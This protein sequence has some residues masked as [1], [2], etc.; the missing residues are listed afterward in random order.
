MNE[1]IITTEVRTIDQDGKQVGVISVNRALEMAEL[2]GLDLV[3]IAPGAEPPVCRIMDF[4]KY[5]YEQ[6]RKIR[7][8]KKHQHV[9]KVKE[10]R[11]HPNIEMHDYNVKLKHAM[12]FLKKGFKIKFGVVFRGREMLHIEHGLE[13]VQKFVTDLKDYGA[14]ESEIKLL[15]RMYLVVIAPVRSGKKSHKEE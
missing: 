2:A 10:I 6:T 8:A 4:G 3:E 1:E 14:K 9:I 15:G 7:E 12:E 13:L 11:L 5:R